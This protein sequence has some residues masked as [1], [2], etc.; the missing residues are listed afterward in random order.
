MTAHAF[1]IASGAEVVP[2]NCFEPLD[3]EAVFART[4]PVEVDLGCAEGSFLASL[5]AANPERNFLGIEKQKARIRSA[6]R[7]IEQRGLTNAKVL[8]FEISLA[9]SELLAGDSVTAFHLMFPDP[10][11]KRRHSSRRLVTAKFLSQLNRAL[12]DGGLLHVATDDPAYFSQIRGYA[13]AAPNFVE[14]PWASSPA[15]SKFEKMFTS[16]GIAI[17]RLSLRKISPVT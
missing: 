4:A 1:N 2:V 14:V 8:R 13:A 12:V 15:M 11:P 3:L 10:W 5:A 9:L 17:H 6:C 16:R 7:K